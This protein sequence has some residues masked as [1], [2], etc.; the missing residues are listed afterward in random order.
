MGANVVGIMG[1]KVVGPNNV[2]AVALEYVWKVDEVVGN[3]WA[4]GSNVIASWFWKLKKCEKNTIL[5][6]PKI[7]DRN[8]IHY[9]KLN[10]YTSSIFNIPIK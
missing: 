4:V 1:S 7:W 2:V 5:Y 6:G 9:I 10:N 8:G 3:N